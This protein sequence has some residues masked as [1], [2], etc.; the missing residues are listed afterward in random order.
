MILDTSAIVAILL[1]E[2]G[3]DH[4]DRAIM[5]SP[6]NEISAGTMLELHV[7]ATRKAI[8]AALQAFVDATPLVVVPVAGPALEWAI[9]GFHT[10][11]K[12][13]HPAALNLG[14]CFAYGLAKALDEPLLFKGDDFS[15][16][17]VMPALA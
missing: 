12:S 13:R 17:D 10:Y 5:E 2:D 15:R 9:H 3:Y 8:D 11:G 7:V 6:R 1:E 14:D 4:F 16:T